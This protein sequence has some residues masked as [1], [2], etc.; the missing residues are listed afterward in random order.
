VSIDHFG[1]SADGKVLYEQFGFTPDHV[2]AA[3]HAA[4][5]RAERIRGTAT[6]N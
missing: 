4:L 3:A 6:G 5:Q 2:I 1:A